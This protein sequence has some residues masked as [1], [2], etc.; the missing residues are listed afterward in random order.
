MIKN[1]LNEME[2]QIIPKYIFNKS[3]LGNSKIAETLKEDLLSSKIIKE[4]T[5]QQLDDGSWDYFHTLSSRSQTN[6]TTEN[7][8][9]RLLLLGLDKTDE[10]IRKAFIYMEQFLK[11][12]IDIRDG[13]EKLSD[14]NEITDLFAAAWMLEIDNES[15][16]AGEVA[17]KW[18]ELI[19]LSFSGESFDFIEYSKAFNDIFHV[20][21]GKRVW[22][23][24]SF[25]IAAILQNRITPDVE[26]KFVNYIL[27]NDKG[28]YYVTHRRKLIDLPETFMSRETS[29][30]LYAHN[31][32]SRYSSY[33]DKCDFVTQWLMENQEDNG[34]WDLGPKARDN[35]FFPLSGSWRNP[36]NRK[37]DSTLYIQKYLKNIGA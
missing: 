27:N 10:P 6:I 32:L 34:F 1:V 30:F 4:I 3:I 23:I 25:H 22:D 21:A 7:A 36:I 17:H 11:K 16:I 26:E 18:A 12:E 15:D 33:K 24:E 20:K 9:R 37:I 31:L 2:M 14:W 5:D 29:R 28:I 13:K 8:V 19:S 35:T